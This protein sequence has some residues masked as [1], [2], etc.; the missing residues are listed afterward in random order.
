MF[1]EKLN[2]YVDAYKKLSMVDKKIAIDKEIKETLALLEKLHERLGKKMKF[3]LI[4][5]FLM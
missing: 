3:Y 1:E 5:K 2:N 4:R